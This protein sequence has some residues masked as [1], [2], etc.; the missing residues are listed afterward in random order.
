[1]HATLRTAGGVYLMARSEAT[2]EDIRKALV[3]NVP[4]SSFRQQREAEASI[5]ART[6]DSGSL[7]A[8][9]LRWCLRDRADVAIGDEELATCLRAV[10][11]TFVAVSSRLEDQSRLAAMVRLK[12]VFPGRFTVPQ[13]E[14]LTQ[15]V[16]A[17]GSFD[18]TL[19]LQS[20]T[21]A[22]CLRAGT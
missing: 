1:M 21:F 6:H 16:Y 5:W 9:H 20:G 4:P 15:S 7:G 2:D 10:E 19:P 18:D 12:T 8:H 3:A 14:A 13:L 11:P 22:E 17:H